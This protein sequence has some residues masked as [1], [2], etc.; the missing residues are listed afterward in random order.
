MDSRNQR[1]NESKKDD[2]QVRL[3]LQC[4]W[5]TVLRTVTGS[6]V[7]STS[8][9]T[10]HRRLSRS[11]L[12][13]G[14]HSILRALQHGSSCRFCYGSAGS[15]ACPPAEPIIALFDTLLSACGVGAITKMP[16]LFSE[17]GVLV[18]Q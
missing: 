18:P 11:V 5:E 3:L 7:F 10:T 1:P 4:L 14:T 9:E 13:L 17:F 16:S 15:G 2:Q 12:G 8:I 6:S